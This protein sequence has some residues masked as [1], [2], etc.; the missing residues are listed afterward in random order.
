MEINM[1][2]NYFWLNIKGEKK[3]KTIKKES[4]KDKK[5]QP[6][7]SSD[8]LSKTGINSSIILKSEQDKETDN[9][10]IEAEEVLKELE[11]YAMAFKIHGLKS[12]INLD[13]NQQDIMVE[14]SMH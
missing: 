9:D 3:E 13:N 8:E 4:S 1:N 10:K 5:D 2:M 11:Q 12:C 7:K 6:Q 14:L